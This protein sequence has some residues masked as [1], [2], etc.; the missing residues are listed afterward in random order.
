M[1]KPKNYHGIM[2]ST[3]KQFENLNENSFI[4]LKLFQKQKKAKEIVKQP[5]LKPIKVILTLES[6]AYECE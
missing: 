4:P 1:L 6:E 3:D 5:T 2:M